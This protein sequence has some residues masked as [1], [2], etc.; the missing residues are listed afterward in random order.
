MTR[1]VEG[2]FV[3]AIG[4]EAEPG[5]ANQVVLRIVVNMQRHPEMNITP[6]TSAFYSFAYFAILRPM[7]I[8]L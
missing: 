4:P 3:G 5:H 2:F 1:A 8:D 7:K 6:S